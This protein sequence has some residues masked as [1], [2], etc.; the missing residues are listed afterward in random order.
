MRLADI[1]RRAHT[2]RR[3]A[4]PLR[5]RTAPRVAG[6]AEAVAHAVAPA[7]EAGHAVVEAAGP[8]AAVVVVRVAVAVAAVAVVAAATVAAGKNYVEKGRPRY[9]GAVP[10]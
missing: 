4:T 3:E 6:L 8:A 5:V 10:I 1:Q 2:V 7:A 9:S